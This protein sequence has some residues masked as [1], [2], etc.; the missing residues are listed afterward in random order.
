[1]PKGIF[2]VQFTVRNGQTFGILEGIFAAEPQFTDLAVPTSEKYVFRGNI[3]VIYDKIAAVPAKFGR[4]D[5]AVFKGNGHL[6]RH[7]QKDDILSPGHQ[8]LEEI[9]IQVLVD[10]RCCEDVSFPHAGINGGAAFLPAVVGPRL[11]VYRIAV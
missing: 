11:V 4:N 2:G 1:M 5:A 3:T 7:V 6:Y 10:H 9:V 8:A